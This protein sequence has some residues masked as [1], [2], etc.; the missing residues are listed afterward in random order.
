MSITYNQP[1]LIF[2]S[3]LSEHAKSAL[4]PVLR[5]VVPNVA[6]K[7][8]KSLDRMTEE[9]VISDTPAASV[10][11]EFGFPMAEIASC[12]EKIKNH[13]KTKPDALILVIDAESVNNDLISDYMRIGISGFVTRPFSESSVT[14]VFKISERL[15]EMGSIAKLKV[16][17][18]L[19]VNSI[20]EKRGEKFEGSS[21]LS[22]VQRA[23]QKFESDNPG[24]STEQIAESYSHLSP[25]ERLKP[26]IKALYKGP[27]ERVK[28]LLKSKVRKD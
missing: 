16:A 15:S 4:L 21:V 5:A 8:F 25:K 7:S 24:I 23:C 11:I 26:Q 9:L 2:V 14:N 12:L 17:T 20:L 28:Q 22:R 13:P 18:R 27:S 19:E 10:F 3:V 6:I 1:T